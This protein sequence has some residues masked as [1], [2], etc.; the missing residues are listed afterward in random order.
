MNLLSFL[1][2]LAVAAVSIGLPP[3]DKVSMSEAFTLHIELAD[4]R[5]DLPRPVQNTFVSVM[6]VG[7]GLNVL[8]SLPDKNGAKTFYV[9]AT[10]NDDPTTYRTFTDCGN[11]PTPFGI[12]LIP[13]ELEKYVRTAYLRPSR[14]YNGTY[15]NGYTAEL[16]PANWLACDEPVE[17]YGGRHFNVLKQVYYE[18]Y[19]TPRECVAVKLFAE[20]AKLNKLPKDAESNHDFVKAV[21]CFRK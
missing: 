14:G 3:S 7:A 17:Y 5:I 4:K 16:T 13:D 15:I 9:N 11:P 20:C 21:T 6:H 10:V 2:P 19:P 8:T 12:N 18:P 1:F